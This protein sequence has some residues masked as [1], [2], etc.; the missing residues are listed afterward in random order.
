MTQVVCQA[1]SILE[2]VANNVNVSCMQ[3]KKKNNERKKKRKK[4][5]VCA[6]SILVSVWLHVSLENLLFPEQNW[7]IRLEDKS[8]GFTLSRT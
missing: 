7:D 2:F 5:S 4:S 1:S 8:Q 6:W 3:K